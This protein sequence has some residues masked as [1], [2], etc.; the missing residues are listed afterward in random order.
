MGLL[1]EASV[2]LRGL[3]E[4]IF[5][6]SNWSPDSANAQN[7]HNLFYTP[8]VNKVLDT[9]ETFFQWFADQFDRKWINTSGFVPFTPLPPSNPAYGTGATAR[10]DC[11]TASRSNGTA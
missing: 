8:A 9:G 6:S 3:G 1:H 11:R 2:V 10:P 5:G 4:V 7:E